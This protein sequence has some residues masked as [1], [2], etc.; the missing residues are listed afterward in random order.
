MNIKEAINRHK[1]L[2][3]HNVL[4]NK[5]KYQ[6]DRILFDNKYVFCYISTQVIKT[7]SNSG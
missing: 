7:L 5:K 6:K 3:I 4:K 1:I 2:S